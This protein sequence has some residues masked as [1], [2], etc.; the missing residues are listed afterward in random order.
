MTFAGTFLSGETERRV[1][2]TLRDGVLRGTLDG[3]PFEHEARA[4]AGAVHLRIDGRWRRA[5][6]ARDGARV[7]VHLEGR[8]HELRVPGAGGGRRGAARRHLAAD[9]PWVV[10]PMTGTVNRVPVAPGEEVEKGA[11]LAVVEAMKIQFVVRAPCRARV[12]AVKVKPGDPVEL[13]QVLVEFERREEKP[14]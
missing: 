14:R 6:V 3:K 9:D 7:L 5:V 11:T 4:E 13:N 12:G 8:V 2:A 10:S 1:S